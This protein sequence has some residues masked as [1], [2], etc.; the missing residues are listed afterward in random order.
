M[1]S[2]VTWC[3]REK[4]SRRAAVTRIDE[5]ISRP[6]QRLTY[7]LAEMSESGSSGTNGP[8]G[9]HQTAGRTDQEP[10]GLSAAKRQ[11]LLSRLP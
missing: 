5:E 6:E 3:M 2:C 4:A 7:L 10:F 9:A 8:S 11:Q 1:V